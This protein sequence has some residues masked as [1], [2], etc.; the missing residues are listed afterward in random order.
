MSAP[1]NYVQ[2]K[3][4]IKRYIDTKPNYELIHLCLK[5]P[6]YKYQYRV[7][8]TT[9]GIDG[10]PEQPM[11]E[12]METYVTVSE[13][14]KKWIDAEAEAVHIILVRTDNDIYSIVDV[15]PNSM[16]IWKSIERLKQGESINV[17]DLETNLYWEF[18]K[19]ISRDGET[20]KDTCKTF[21]GNTCDLGSILEETGQEYDFTPK[22]GLKNKSQMVETASGKLATPFGS[23]S[24]HVRKSYDGVCT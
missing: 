4:R 15:C 14:T 8:H 11:E 21:R 5:N 24:D 7:P 2:W 22:E 9:P 23:A 20:N 19:F 6:P 17:Q 12:V 16:E 1:S 10:T 3:S 13:E 18:G